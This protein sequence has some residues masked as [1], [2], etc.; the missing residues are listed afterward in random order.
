MKL[1]VNTSIYDGYDLDT[2]LNSIKKCGFDYFELAYNQAY[3]S[4]LNQNLFSIENVLI[5]SK[6]Y[7]KNIL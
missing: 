2:T 7:I 4:N 1:S 6:E 3:V 5:K